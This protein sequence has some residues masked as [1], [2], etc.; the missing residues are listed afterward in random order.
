MG[1]HV[2]IAVIY[3]GA[4]D[5]TELVLRGL[6]TPTRIDLEDDGLVAG[7]EHGATRVSIYW[8]DHDA[9]PEYGAY[10]ER[11]LLY[12]AAKRG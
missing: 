9:V 1:D 10:G 6:P 8:P 11:R 7:A 12:R 3:G 2:I 5:G 4:H